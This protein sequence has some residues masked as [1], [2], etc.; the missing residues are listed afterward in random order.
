MALYDY[1][2]NFIISL[3]GTAMQY[4]STGILMRYI[5]M[6]LTLAMFFGLIYLL[7]L[8]FKIVIRAFRG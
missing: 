1:V 3:M 8:F 6:G 2:Y 4:E 7:C 5:A